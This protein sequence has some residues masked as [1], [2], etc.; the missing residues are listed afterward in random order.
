MASAGRDNTACVDLTSTV[1]GQGILLTH[2]RDQLDK[3]SMHTALDYLNK[4]L[5]DDA[6]VRRLLG[7]NAGFQQVCPWLACLF[8]LTA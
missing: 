1:V 8:T 3:Y 4:A 5:L 2:L 7:M 6:S